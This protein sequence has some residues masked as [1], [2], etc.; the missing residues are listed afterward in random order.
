ML[1]NCAWEELWPA[2]REDGSIDLKSELVVSCIVVVSTV[3]QSVN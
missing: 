1:T 2:V 3:A